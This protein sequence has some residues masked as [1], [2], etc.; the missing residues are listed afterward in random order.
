MGSP[1]ECD[2]CKK[3]KAELKESRQEHW[4]NL[5]TARCILLNRIEDLQ[6]LA[7]DVRLKELR[8]KKRLKGG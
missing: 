5:N 1:E 2:N 3:L 6:T 8:L 4:A 7:E